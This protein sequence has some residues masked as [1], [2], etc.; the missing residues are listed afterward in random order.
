MCS[1]SHRRRD[2]GFSCVPLLRQKFT[3]GVPIRR[4]CS[5][6]RKAEAKST[7]I[8]LV[9]SSFRLCKSNL[10]FC[11]WREYLTED[12]LSRVLN[13]GQFTLED[14][15]STVQ[16]RFP[17][18]SLAKQVDKVQVNKIESVSNTYKLTREIYCN[19]Q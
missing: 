15:S 17:I 6:L 5:F 1:C 18:M 3:F 12:I 19:M 4:K 10:A 11:N 2:F 8:G 7:V 16:V 14:L 9:R 13:K